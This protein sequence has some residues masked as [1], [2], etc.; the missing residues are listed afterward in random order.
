M[1][2]VRR[3]G[4]LLLILLA[5]PLI[6]AFFMQR[7]FVV[8]RSVVIAKPLAEVFDYLRHIEHQREYSVWAKADPE[9]KWSSAGNDGEQGYVIG[10]ASEDSNVGVGE[11]EIITIVPDARIDTEIRFTEPFVSRSSLSIHTASAGEDQTKIT[12]MYSGRMDY[13]SN[14]LCSFIAEKI[15]AGMQ[16]NLENVKAILER[17]ANPSTQ[18]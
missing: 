1:R 3:V 8:Q 14:L 15:G 11:Q 6:G 9:A 18:E 12:C 16:A 13:P 5:I 10:W 17:P 2:T 4:L 7:D